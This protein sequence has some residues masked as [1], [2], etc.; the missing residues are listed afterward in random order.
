MY[1][2][3]I[4]LGRIRQQIPGNTTLNLDLR[5]F[6]A[7]QNRIIQMLGTGLGVNNAII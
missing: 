4:L 5:P 1:E 3:D 7:T 6:V 2:F